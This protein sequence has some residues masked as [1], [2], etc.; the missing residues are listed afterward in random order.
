MEKYL[1]EY[2]VEYIKNYYNDKEYDSSYPDEYSNP[3][4]TETGIRLV[5]GEDHMDAYFNLEWFIK[6][7]FN[8]NDNDKFHI[9]IIDLNI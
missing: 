7:T 3:V 5:S 9:K 4:I 2:K 8:F 6:D 1:F